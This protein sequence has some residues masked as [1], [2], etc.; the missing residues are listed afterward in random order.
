MDVVC[1]NDKC[2]IECMP[3]NEK[4]SEAFYISYLCEDVRLGFGY[5][6][7]C[8]C[9]K[10]TT[11]TTNP[12]ENEYVR[13]TEQQ[14]ERM[15]GCVSDKPESE[16]INSIGFR[17]GWCCRLCTC[18]W[19][20]LN[21]LV[22]NRYRVLFKI[23]THNSRGA[24]ERTE[25]D[26]GNSSKKKSNNI[27]KNNRAAMRNAFVRVRRAAKIIM[28]I[29]LTYKQTCTPSAAVFLRPFYEFL[30]IIL[31]TLEN[32]SACRNLKSGEMKQCW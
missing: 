12:N 24:S 11:T 5:V 21:A 13:S 2:P 17:S 7:S 22:A 4:S 32:S 20:R 31:S 16:W 28:L 8:V 19:A 23:R 25:R 27:A 3:Q 9:T 6:Q 30:I 14:S 18:V 1:K 15:D 26:E 10:R 29:Q